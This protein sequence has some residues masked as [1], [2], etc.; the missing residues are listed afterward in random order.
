MTDLE[1]KFLDKIPIDKIYEDLFKLGMKKAGQALE[2]VIE[3]GLTILLPIKL[4]NEKAKLRLKSHLDNY[5]RKLEAVEAEKICNVPEHIGLPII[6]KLTYLDQ[7][8]LSEGFI[9]LLTKASSI[10]TVNLV[11][12]GF[13]DTLNNLCADE[14]K[15]LNHF[16]TCDRIPLIDLHV[17]KYDEKIPKPD[18]ASIRGP[19]TGEQLK[20]QAAYTFQ[21][22]NEVDLTVAW[23]LTGIEEQVQL[24]FP[25]NID[26]YL[27]NLLR[28][29]IIKFER[30]L[31]S[32]SDDDEY[33]KLEEKTY[34]D[35]IKQVKDMMA[36]VT[37]QK[38]EFF[39][40]RGFI[41]FTEYGK[42]FK[43]ACIID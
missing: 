26:I 14:A 23:N 35:N 38:T 5:S 21:E 32:R 9:R 22:R 30:S 41:T 7:S 40:A 36:E 19:R 3:F 39:I 4:L 6:D 28:Q 43:N 18:F 29:G 15:I 31:F 24:D 34:A 11:H 13:L 16:K 10:D 1:K 25:K 33:L 20:Q 8:D 17:R 27:D 37:D 2:T 42:A 12:P